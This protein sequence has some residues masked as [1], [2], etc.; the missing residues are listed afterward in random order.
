LEELSAGRYQRVAPNDRSMRL[1]ARLDELLKEH[2]DQCHESFK[3][4]HSQEFFEKVELIVQDDMGV[5]LP[6]HLD[7]TIAYQ[8]ITNLLSEIQFHCVGLIEEVLG[9]CLKTAQYLIEK[10]FK[11]FKPVTELV[12]DKVEQEMEEIKRNT[13][14]E[15][16]D[17]IKIER[18]SIY[19]SPES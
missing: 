15:L 6:N 13:V 4:F 14:D 5:H 17:M 18:S 9:L 8:F 7:F 12:L 10:H 19:L 2:V 11:R 16:N 3:H 1:R